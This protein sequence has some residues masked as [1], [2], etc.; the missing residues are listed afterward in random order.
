[1]ELRPRMLKDCLLEDS[2]SCSSNGFKSMPRR[3]SLNPFPMI[4]K[5]KKQSSA[6]RVVI[7]AVKNLSS[8]A[9]KST[10]SGILPR[11]L[12]RRLSSSKNKAENKANITTIIRVKDIVRW[13]S[14]KD[15]LHEDT[16][17][18]K[19]HQYTTKT[20]TGSSTGSDTSSSSW[21]DSDFTSEFLPSAWGGNVEKEE[22]G[23]NHKLQCVGEDS[24][25]A[26]TDADTVVGPEDLQCEEEQN[27][28]VSVLEIQL[29]E[30]DEASNSSFS[31]C[32]DNVERTK[33]KLMETIQRFENLANI[34]PFNLEEWGE[35]SC[36]D[37][38]CDTEI[39][40]DE[41]DIDE[42][43]EK[44]A[45]LWERVKERD[46]I[47][48]HEEHLIM[49]YFRDELMQRTNETH[50]QHFEEQLVGEAK[51]WLSGQRISELECG[52]GEQRRQACAR[53]IERLDWNE[54]RMKEEREEVAVQ[55][56][57]GLFSLLMNETLNALYEQPEQSSK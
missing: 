2:N 50:H 34:S 48:I 29:G 28:P 32:L 22:G 41:D 15:L 51:G 37:E 16:S 6:L 14:S 8:N 26:V 55:V 19:P 44:A 27:S 49:D 42:V 43:A 12:S 11:S 35:E 36:K 24:C 7:N 3:P 54:K 53:E 1:M 46:D 4:P 33:Q 18:F 31:Q 25:T 52:T 39:E 10:P 20:I 40:E 56:E 30:D 21:C 5:K 13:S 38:S 23:E 57:D 9:I 45:E 17:H 47:W